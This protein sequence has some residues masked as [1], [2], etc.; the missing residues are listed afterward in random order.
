MQF[1]YFVKAPIDGTLTYTGFLQE[2]QEIKNGTSL[3]NVQPANTNYFIEM[4]IPQYNFGKV[5]IGQEV[6]LKFQ[7]YPFE[8][9][10][11]VVGTID[12]I[13]KTPTDSGYLAKVVLPKGLTTNYNKPLQ[14]L[15]N[16]NATA[17]IIT[18]NM[19][20]LQRFYNNLTKQINS[21]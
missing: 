19:R 21:R 8:Q 9:Y 1:K 15:N 7:A 2:N 17:E 6:L 13:N 3:F 16:A 11:S 12:Y 10:G 5:K 14:Y 20:L 18:E 4:L